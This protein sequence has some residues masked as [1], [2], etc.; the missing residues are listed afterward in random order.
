MWYDENEVG[1]SR[2]CLFGRAG[3]T[4][5][6]VA[7]LGG[8]YFLGVESSDSPGGR[9]AEIPQQTSAAPPEKPPSAVPVQSVTPSG[10]PVE[11][12]ELWLR[13]FRTVA[14]TDPKPTSW[15]DRIQ[16]LLTETMKAQM[17]QPGEESAGAGWEEFVTNRCSSE[18]RDLGGVIPPE[19]PSTDDVVNVQIAGVVHTECAHR[20]GL[21][22][23]DEPVAATL[24][25]HRA[26]DMRWQVS[27][28]LY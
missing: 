4:L 23:P 5:A 13:G 24:E 9:P 27:R 11:T 21:T 6:V 19:A 10:D 15:A 8:A 16:P 12:A 25:L 2:R 18:V 14:F 22:P 7:V 26:A 3:G 17:G 20:G 1:R 28:R